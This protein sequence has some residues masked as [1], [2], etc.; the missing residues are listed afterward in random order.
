MPKLKTSKELMKFLGGLKGQLKKNAKDIILV[1][2]GNIFSVDLFAISVIHRSLLLIAGFCLLIKK[3]NFLSAAPIIRLYL[4]TLLQF[5]ALSIV[6]DPNE[7]AMKKL[8]GK[9]TN[10]L[11]DRDGNKMTDGY[12]LSQIA[13]EKEFE[14][15]EN[16]Y[17]ETSKFIH[18]ID[19]HILSACTKIK[20][21]GVVTF[22][23]SDKI[24]TPK[25]A[26]RE[27]IITMIAITNGLLT[28]LFCNG[29]VFTKNNPYSIKKN[30]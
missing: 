10:N 12:L 1:D 28:Y 24:D 23:L 29:W 11:K 3:S 26:E 27:A 9:Q 14:W 30:K 8:N 20:A 16:V 22:C 19:K 21:N 15:V 18:F 17:K 2:G 5:Y 6:K 4:D 7:F 25:S 13:K